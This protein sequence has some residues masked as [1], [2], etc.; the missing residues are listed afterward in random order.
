MGWGIGVV[1]LLVFG[2]L[3]AE[4][5]TYS[6]QWTIGYD[7]ITLPEDEAMGLMHAGALF[8]VN[9]YMRLGPELYGAVS[10]ERGGFFTVGME[11][12][13]HRELVRRLEILAGLF[14]GA[15]GGGAAPQGG[16]LMVRPRAALRYDLGY[17]SVEAGISRVWFPN[18]EIDSS[19]FAMAVQLPFAGRFWRGAESRQ[20][21]GTVN[22]QGLWIDVRPLVEHYRPVATAHSTLNDAIAT[23]PY[24]LG[25]ISFLV[26]REDSPLYG[27]LQT[28]GAGAGDATGYMEVFGGIGYRRRV[29]ER[30]TVGLQGALGAGGG[31]RIDTGGGAMYR[32]EGVV[33][34][35]IFRHLHLGVQAGYIGAFKGSFAATGLGMSI[36]Y[37]H[38]FFGIGDPEF[39]GESPTTPWR[40]RLLN[41]S[42][43]PAEG[44]FNDDQE[45]R[46]DL[47][48]VGIDR[49]V[50]PN[51]YIGGLSYW[52]WQGEAGGYAEGAFTFGWESDAYRGWHAYAEAVVG[53]GGG[54]D[55]HMDGGLFG[56]IGGG[57]RYDID[58]A[59]QLD[60][61]AEYVRS[62]TGG[63]RTTSLKAGINYRFSLFGE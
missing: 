44:M 62:R 45:N 11:G 31:G 3:W 48:G 41:K 10:G 52:A 63:F 39:D 32:A 40:F 1:F 37:Q 19:Q 50:T 57:V 49:F 56:S 26:S 33:D 5:A 7:P 15:G 14:V 29:A 18:G 53:V 24:T 6:G 51:L 12:E 43:L 30:L 60:V 16:G 58:E 27:Y 28:A 46:I 38:R 13:L 22:G 36:G 34:A 61:G 55:V 2:R 54:G 9:R 4:P 25:G 23:E 8:D 21:D 59:W 35:Q 47:I 20:E 17:V 42:Y